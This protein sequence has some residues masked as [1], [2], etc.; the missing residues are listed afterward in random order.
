MFIYVNVSTDEIGDLLIS[1]IYFKGQIPCYA[2]GDGGSLAA[3]NGVRIDNTR[4]FVVTNCRFEHFGAAGIRVMHRDRMANGLIYNN[5]FI[6]NYKYKV[7]LGYGVSVYGNN[8]VI[9]YA[10]E[11]RPVMCSV[12][13]R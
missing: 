8:T 12:T 4:G 13:T 1:D 11:A 6:H 10:V 2:T 3:D 5:E 9:R 7:D